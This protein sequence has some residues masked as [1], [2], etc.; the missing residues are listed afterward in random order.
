MELYRSNKF[1]LFKT[2]YLSITFA[3]F[4][5]ILFWV[6]FQESMRAIDILYIFPM[7][8]VAK[9]EIQ[10]DWDIIIKGI[11][12]FRQSTNKEL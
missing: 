4:L 5:P 11:P 9:N 2:F 6:L 12:F 10:R 3:L 8:K 1:Y 7:K